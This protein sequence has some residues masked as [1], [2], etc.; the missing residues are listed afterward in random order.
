MKAVIL[1]AAIFFTLIRAISQPSSATNIAAGSS[2]PRPCW[3]RH[4]SGDG[5]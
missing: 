2:F 4:G 5:F 3:I 1:S